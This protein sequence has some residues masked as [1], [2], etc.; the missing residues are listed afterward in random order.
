MMTL[1]DAIQNCIEKTK[2]NE[3]TSSQ[4]RMDF[5]INYYKKRAEEHRQLAEW[6]TEL[7]SRRDMMESLKM[8]IATFKEPMKEKL[9][10][11][12]CNRDYLTGYLC[13]LSV[14]EGMIAE[15]QDGSN[16]TQNID[17]Q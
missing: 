11:G 1:D 17:K 6:L 15:I 3:R 2:H 8:Q 14:V 12:Q 13:A 4:M 9:E 16:N 5:N 10:K 7:K